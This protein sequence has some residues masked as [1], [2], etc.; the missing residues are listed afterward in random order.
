MI[1]IRNLGEKGQLV[2]PKDMRDMFGL[3]NGEEVV[4][5]TVS[6]GINIRAKEED[7][8]KILEDFLNVPGK[9]KRQSSIKELKK[10]ID[11]QYDEEIP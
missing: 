2:I 10:I 5:E 7:V 6:N 9:K 4:L 11:E 3:R 8:E 1:V